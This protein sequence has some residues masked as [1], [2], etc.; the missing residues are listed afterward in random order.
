MNLPTSSST[1]R[2]MLAR[3]V[4]IATAG[5]Q[6]VVFGQRKASAIQYCRTRVSYYIQ[7][8]STC[9]VRWGPPSCSQSCKYVESYNGS[10]W[11]GY[12]CSC[13]PQACNCSPYYVQARAA[14]C[15]DGKCSGHCWSE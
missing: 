12:C 4:A 8:T 10:Y 5:F 14:V 2:R 6:V 9:N 3:A 1:R 7:S 15:N 11:F 13:Q